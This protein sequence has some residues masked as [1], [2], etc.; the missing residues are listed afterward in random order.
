MSKYNRNFNE[1]IPNIF[2]L[3]LNSRK[4]KN[5]ISSCKLLLEKMTSMF[6]LVYAAHYLGAVVTF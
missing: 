3:R 1:K 5:L 4:T 6:G 2:F